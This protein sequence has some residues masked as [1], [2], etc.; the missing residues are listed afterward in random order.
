ME[1]GAGGVGGT[2]EGDE[3]WVEVAALGW[4]YECLRAKGGEDMEQ[5]LEVGWRGGSGYL[6]KVSLVFANGCEGTGESGVC[7]SMGLRRSGNVEERRKGKKTSRHCGRRMGRLRRKQQWT[8]EME[9]TC[10]AFWPGRG[11]HHHIF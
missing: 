11:D 8:M 6:A 1:L 5:G 9:I 2:S 7:R 4:R 10:S 3:K